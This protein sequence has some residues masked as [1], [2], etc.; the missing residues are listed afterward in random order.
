MAK[1]GSGIPSITYDEA[2][3]IA[4]CYGWIDSRKEAWDETYWIQ[5]FGPRGPRSI[6]SKINKEK[7]ER[8][9]TEGRMKPAGLAAIEEAKQKGQ[10]EQAYAS[11][12]RSQIPE[13]LERKFEEHPDAAAFFA[14]LDSR[15]K[16]AVL[17]R[18]QSAKKPETRAK[19]IDQFIDMLEKRRKNISLDCASALSCKEQPKPPST[20]GASPFL[21]LLQH[22]PS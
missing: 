5:R 17:F 21:D 15:N 1:K 4:L 6:W 20:T 8:L 11:Q 18:V 12:S 10:W 9:V 16:Y 19:R 14:T 13:D 7:A 2:L 22:F 3:E